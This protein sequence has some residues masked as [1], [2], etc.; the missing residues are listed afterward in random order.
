MLFYLVKKRFVKRLPAFR[1]ARR[2]YRLF[3]IVESHR[4]RMRSDKFFGVSACVFSQ[5]QI[6]ISLAVG[7]IFRNKVGTKS[8]DVVKVGSLEKVCRNGKLRLV[9]Y[10]YLPLS[11]SFELTFGHALFYDALFLI[12]SRCV[13]LARQLGSD[14]FGIPVD[15]IY[16]SLQRVVGVEFD[17]LYLAAYARQ[18]LHNAVCKYH[19]KRIAL[20]FFLTEHIEITRILVLYPRSLQIALVGAHQQHTLR[21]VQSV[22]YQR[23]VIRARPVL[24]LLFGIKRRISRVL[25]FVIKRIG[26]MTVFRVSAAVFRNL[27]ANKTVVIESGFFQ[28]VKLSANTVD[29]FCLES[30]FLL[31]LRRG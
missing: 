4:I 18:S 6:P 24:Y 10:G 30:I 22:K 9:G 31:L 27:D 20:F 1:F 19:G 16:Y 29:F 25:Q 15:K 3:E 2:S 17:T 26:D 12:R 28:L 21:A 11:D 13:F 7:W 8:L 23:F 5:E 14:F